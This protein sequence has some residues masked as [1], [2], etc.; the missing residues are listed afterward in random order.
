MKYA[1]V[2]YAIVP[3]NAGTIAIT[4]IKNQILKTSVCKYTSLT[5]LSGG[6]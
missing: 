1:T 6:E 3:Y 2:I 5:R 4:T